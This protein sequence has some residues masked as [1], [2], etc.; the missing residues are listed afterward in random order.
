MPRTEKRF[1]VVNQPTALTQNELVPTAATT[2]NLLINATARTSAVI[3]AAIYSGAYSN[4]VNQS[5]NI[6][7]AAISNMSNTASGAPAGETIYYLGKDNVYMAPTGSTNQRLF[8]IDPNTNSVQY[9][10]NT[11][12]ITVSNYWRGTLQSSQGHKSWVTGG[13]SFT[14]F[15]RRMVMI[16]SSRALGI[17][18]GVITSGTANSDMFDAVIITHTVGSS[19]TENGSNV[20]ETGFQGSTGNA[21]GAHSGSVYALQ[22]GVGYILH[23]GETATTQTNGRT[24]MGIYIYSDSSA[25]FQ[26]RAYW[27]CDGTATKTAG[28]ALSYFFATDYNPTHQVFAFSQ[29]STTTLWSGIS[30]TSSTSWPAGYA[31]PSEAA[32]AGFRIVSN[33]GT[34]EPDVNFLTGDITYPAAPTGVTVPTGIVPVVSLKFSPDGTKLAVAYRRDYSGSGNTNSVAVVYTRQEDGT[35]LHTHSSGSEIPHQVHAMNTMAWSGDG[36]MIAIA[37][38]TNSSSLNVNGNQTVYLWRIGDGSVDYV[39]N[40]SV[41]TWT[42][43]SSKYPEFSGYLSPSSGSSYIGSSSISSVVLSAKAGDV[44]NYS[45][46]SLHYARTSSSGVAGQFIGAISVNTV[47]DIPRAVRSIILQPSGTVG[48]SGVPATNYVTMAVSDLALTAG[49]TTQVSNIVLGSGDRVYVESSTS[50]SVD[51]SAHGIEST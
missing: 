32:P 50:N 5:L 11:S 43:L 30:P 6:S 14:A 13:D 19:I 17:G 36:S 12:T 35:W 4:D 27:N 37:G 3:S 38:T 31:L 8:V 2:R 44:N 18:A 20:G 15:G 47:S 7:S 25:A 1:G 21:G 9:V 33:S 40:T 16:S 22:D 45:Y 10:G 34:A 29:P 51:I 39:A 28:T 49:Q 42:N 41:A 24:A 23:S 48:T 26:K 46:G